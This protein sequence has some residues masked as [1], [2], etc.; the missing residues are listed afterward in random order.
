MDYSPDQ[1][2]ATPLAP[3]TSGSPCESS[4]VTPAAS[5]QAPGSGSNPLMSA[6]GS[7]SQPLL[8]AALARAAAG[9]SPSL[10]GTASGA[11]A[12]NSPARAATLLPSASKTPKPSSP[13]SRA[14]LGPVTGITQ[15]AATA[16][17]NLKVPGD[18][19][20]T[21]SKQPTA[22]GRQEDATSSAS[23][24]S[25]HSRN[26]EGSNTAASTSKPADA[27]AVGLSRHPGSKTSIAVDAQ[28]SSLVP[29]YCT[30]GIEVCLH[31][32]Q[33]SAFGLSIWACI[34]LILPLLASDGRAFTCTEDSAMP[35]T[36]GLLPAVLVAHNIYVHR[37]AWLACTQC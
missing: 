11:A 34:L 23:F 10:P 5:L 13:R 25:W 31:R 29:V 21:A 12:G 20:L 8:V 24:D 1:P 36:I 17:G 2:P 30:H 22:L 27:T 14:S 15:E 35:M 18:S 7:S 4:A 37:Q 16:V 6:K 19:S 9:N 3:S 33:A 26:Y 32:V 28:G